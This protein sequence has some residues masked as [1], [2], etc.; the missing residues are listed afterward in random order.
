M[1][2]REIRQQPIY[3]PLKK[4]K[5]L[6][7]QQTSV[8]STAQCSINDRINF[9]G[10]RYTSNINRAKDIFYS[11]IPAYHKEKE[12]I[13][14]CYLNPLFNSNS[15]KIKPSILLCSI[16]D[17]ILHKFKDGIMSSA[18]HMGL[19]CIDFTSEFEKTSWDEKLNQQLNK[20]KEIYERTGRRSIIFIDNA[21]K[22]IGMNEYDAES[23][24]DFNFD[25]ADLQLLKTNNNIDII[26]KFK[27]LTDI[28][29]K[30]PNTFNDGY[31]TTFIF[32]TT[33]PHIIH[34]DFRDGKMERKYIALPQKENFSTL[35]V[36]DLDIAKNEILPLISN[37][38]M[39]N[40]LS[41][42]EFVPNTYTLLFFNILMSPNQFNGAYSNEKII[43]MMKKAIFKTSETTNPKNFFLI[44]ADVVCKTSRDISQDEVKKYNLVSKNYS[45]GID[46]YEILQAMNNDGMLD[47]NEQKELDEIIIKEKKY[48]QYLSDKQNLDLLTPDEEV[49]LE[50]LKNRYTNFKYAIIRDI[51]YNGKQLEYANG[52][53]A[54][55]YYG[56][57]G[58]N[59]SILWIEPASIETLNGVL[60]NLNLLKNQKQFQSI[61]KIQISHFIGI[62][63]I[64]WMRATSQKDYYGK[65]IYEMELK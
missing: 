51:P 21:E 32:T 30:V 3:I 13:F 7:F 5:S 35:L 23:R 10:D 55:L 39:I 15:L 63:G 56:D 36:E 34:P 38:N 64:P 17:S 12:E 29:H 46:K 11:E 52:K 49:I 60:T 33:F 58:Y 27:T 18:K 22:I 4:D 57:S 54:N 47:I 9:K 14:D 19:N 20:N 8:N 59:K 42:L 6:I 26:N 24:S 31:A 25:K 48:G 50:K 16:D 62:D 43:K 40:E 37:L 28:C 61:G 65:T 2:V 41:K 45:S 53:K 1:Q 44:L